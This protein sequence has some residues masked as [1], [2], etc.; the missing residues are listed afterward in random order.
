MGTIC[1]SILL[2]FCVISGITAADFYSNLNKSLFA[3]P[4]YTSLGGA[5]LVFS[6]DAAPLSSPAN[7]PLEP[8]NEASLAYT[9]FYENSFSTSLA[10]LRINPD[11]KI[12]LGLCVGYLY[13]PDIEITDGLATDTNQN[14]VFDPSRLDYSSSSEIFLNIALGYT[15]FKAK[16]FI[17]SVGASLHCQ[18]RRLVDWTGYGIGVD[19]AGTMELVKAGV[20]FS[21][22]LDDITTNYIHWSSDYHDIGLPHAR[23]GVGWRRDIPYIYGRISVMYKTPDLF[24]NE[25][26]VYN[27]FSEKN[28]SQYEPQKSSLKDEPSLLFSAGVYGAEYMIQRVVALRFG[29]DDT[30]RIFFGGGVNL[31]KQA[32]FFD[33]SYMVAYELPGTYSLCMGYHW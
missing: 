16:N 25:G 30:K 22:L 18:R 9:G 31:F 2:F 33:F 15:F 32:L 6:G 20:R 23:M 4:R 13:I 19:V 5:N 12:G 21:L 29:L 27:V 10:S 8:T 24:S 3:F 11:G 1:K 28:G 17:S 26:V 14:P 7:I